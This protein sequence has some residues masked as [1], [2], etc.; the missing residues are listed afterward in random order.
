MTI[1]GLTFAIPHEEANSIEESEVKMA[2]VITSLK[3]SFTS[4][5]EGTLAKRLERKTAR[6]PSDV[7]LWSAVG[8]IGISAALQFMNRRERSLFIGQWVPSLLIIGV[9]NKLVKLMGSD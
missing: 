6:I 8:A 9:Y 4:Q 7:Y 1:G 2:G 5:R 3:D